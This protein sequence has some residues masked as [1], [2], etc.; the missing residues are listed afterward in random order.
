MSIS[1]NAL[2]TFSDC[3]KAYRRM[4]KGY[5]EG[6]VVHSTGANNPNLKRYVNCP[7]VCGYN[8]FKNYFGGKNSDDVMPH[9]VIGKD[10]NGKIKCAKL[11]PFNIC[12]WGCASGNRGSYNWNPAYLQFEICEDNLKDEKY[13]NEAFDLA[14]RFCARLMK[15]Y[16]SIKLENI[17]SH[18]EA[19]K[20]GYASQHVDPHN[21][22]EKFGKD[23]NWF[24]E[25]VRKQAVMEGVKFSDSSSAPAAPYKVKVETNDLNIRSKPTTDSTIVGQVK[26]SIYT[27]VEEAKGK[28]ATKW[29]KLKSGIGWISLDYVTKYK[30]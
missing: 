23:M 27:I 4:P 8:L 16:P 7:S 1:F 25:K 18:W 5:P 17:V 29:G 21:W 28:G 22:L 20:R 15:N 14:A 9:A 13:F 6:I 10:K 30:E 12:C 19:H 11:L 24:R 2:T 3:Y 26:P